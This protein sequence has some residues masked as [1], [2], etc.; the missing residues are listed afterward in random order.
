M[1]PTSTISLDSPGGLTDLAYGSTYGYDLLPPK[2]T[3]PSQQREKSLRARCRE[4][5]ASAPMGPRQWGLKD[6]LVIY[7]P[8]ARHN[9]KF[10]LP[11]GKQ[12]PDRNH[13]LCTNSEPSYQGL[14]GSLP[15]CKFQDV[16]QR[17]NLARLTLRNLPGFANNLDHDKR[18]FCRF[19]AGM[20]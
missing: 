11:Q 19:L 16:S 4:D 13:I 18:S 15:K 7:T 9:P 20:W 17:T 14:V 1:G 12:L 10:Q 8:S 3:K 2:A 6:T 5:Q